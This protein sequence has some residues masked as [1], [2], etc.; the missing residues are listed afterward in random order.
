MSNNLPLVCICIPTYNTASTVR[1]TLASILNQTYSNLVVHVSD[2]ASTD[3]TLKVIES[4]A[5]ARVTIHRHEENIGGE[6]NFNRCIQLA[7]GKYTAIFHADD[8]YDP[9][10][11]AKQVAFLEAN[12]EAGAVFT[13]A[14][15]IN[16]SG[17]IVGELKLPRGLSSPN[18]LYD[19]AQ[20][21]K[22][23]L[24]RLNFFVCPSAMV[25][26]GIYQNEIKCWRAEMFKSS[27][28]VDV[29]LRISRQH[30]VGL[31]PTPL[32]RYRISNYQF[33]AS[34]RKQTER[35][36]FFLVMDFYLAQ[37]EIQHL[38]TES[39]RMHYKWLERADRIRRA[40]NL[41]MCNRVKEAYQLCG[42]ILSFDALRAAI[43][44]RRGLLTLLAGLYVR[45]FVL[46]RLHVLGQK[47]MN[48]ARG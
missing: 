41:F 39:D 23:T 42:D 16:E 45:L 5:D 47:L 13:E 40:V 19:F 8:I 1:E 36:D 44:S 27:A 25:R 35:I 37:D 28:D 34:V 22:T 18:H 10:M 24:H 46:L 9:D 31:L 15:L 43:D 12:P 38:L 3:D 6:G 4:I 32:M 20:L 21:F 7:E 11:V 2:N 48:F 26:T 17:K 29:W 33:S 30:P 14:K